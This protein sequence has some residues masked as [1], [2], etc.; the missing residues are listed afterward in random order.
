MANN[1]GKT[2]INTDSSENKI[3]VNMNDVVPFQGTQKL[4]NDNERLIIKDDHS[5][6]YFVNDQLEKSG[7]WAY[8]DG[9]LI[10]YLKDY[11]GN[12]YKPMFCTI[13]CENRKIR[14]LKVNGVTY[15]PW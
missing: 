11:E 6:K 15:R 7:T 10:F 1:D 12:T 14:Y 2:I 5:V 4:Y 3:V 13:K 9:G 8:E